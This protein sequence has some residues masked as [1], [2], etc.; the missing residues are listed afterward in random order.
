MSQ[1]HITNNNNLN[2]TLTNL[3]IIMWGEKAIKGKSCSYLALGSNASRWFLGHCQ[4][5]L[6]VVRSARFIKSIPTIIDWNC[7]FSFFKAASNFFRPFENNWNGLWAFCGFDSS[8]W[9][10]KAYDFFFFTSILIDE[11]QKHEFCFEFK[12]NG[13]KNA[14]IDS[15]Y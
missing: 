12:H 3:I 7:S 11:R 15:G 4:Y 1:T 8:G 5:S 6:V 13:Q 10:R 2:C 14:S 9:K